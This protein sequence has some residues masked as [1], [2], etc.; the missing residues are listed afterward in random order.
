LPTTTAGFKLLV[1]SWFNSKVSANIGA[2]SEDIGANQGVILLLMV[3]RA[4]SDVERT[5]KGDAQCTP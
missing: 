5:T 3:R 1:G 2:A 4:E